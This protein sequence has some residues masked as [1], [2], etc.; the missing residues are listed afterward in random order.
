VFFFVV[1]GLLVVFFGW[2][3]GFG[4]FLGVCGEGVLWGKPELGPGLDALQKRG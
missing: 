3:G 4:V 1:G 2:G